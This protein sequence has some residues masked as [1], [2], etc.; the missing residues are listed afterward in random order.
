MPLAAGRRGLVK[1]GPLFR[2]HATRQEIAQLDLFA[3]VQ[4]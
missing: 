2:S 4:P 3:E 1:P